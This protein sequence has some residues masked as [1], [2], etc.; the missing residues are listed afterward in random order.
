MAEDATVHD[1]RRL[2]GSEVRH[3]RDAALAMDRAFGE[4]G[5]DDADG[6]VLAVRGD[7]LAL[8]D[9]TSQTADE[10]E[11]HYLLVFEINDNHQLASLT[12]HDPEHLADAI[13]ELDARYLAGEG[14]ALAPRHRVGFRSFAAA[15]A[16]DWDAFR[17]TYSPE[18]VCTDRRQIGWPTLDRDGLVDTMR[19]YSELAPDLFLLPRKVEI[20]GRAQ[21]FTI[22]ASGTT[23]DGGAVEWV[24]HT[25]TVVG[26]DR[27]LEHRDLRRARLRRRARALRR[28]RRRRCRRPP[29][30]AR[31]ERGDSVERP[32]PGAVHPRPIR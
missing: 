13:D 20:Q 6:S 27:H 21:L 4:V 1:R 31:R 17:D 15:N 24:Q 9:A 8:L 2:I 32:D 12:F 5:F 16:R 7:R 28:A 11:I 30:P 22:D 18:L 14:A 25:V 23:P 3:G 26:A 29:P 10:Y 19:E